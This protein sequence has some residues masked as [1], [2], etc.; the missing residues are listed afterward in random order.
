MHVKETL[1]NLL[2]I[3]LREKFHLKSEGEINQL[4]EQ[5]QNGTL[6]DWQWKKIVNKMYDREDVQILSERFGECIEQRR[7][8]KENN[9]LASSGA[10]PQAKINTRKLSRD[11]ELRKRK[12]V[13]S[14]NRLTYQEFLKIILDFQL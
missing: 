12:Q 7:N 8:K 10:M 1:Q 13:K 11:E 9:T 4:C 3:L 5:I 14:E 2:K 6:E